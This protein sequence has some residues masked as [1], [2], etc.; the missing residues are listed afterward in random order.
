[1]FLSLPK[2]SLF[3]LFLQFQNESVIINQINMKIKELR[4]KRALR[5]VLLVLL[6]NAAGMAKGQYQDCFFAEDGLFYGIL[7]DNPSCVAVISPGYCGGNEYD[8]VNLTLTNTVVLEHDDG[9]GM[10]HDVY[11][12]VSIG[13][14][15]FGYCTSLTSIVIPNSVTTIG[16]GAFYECT[17]LASIEI[18]NL[19][20]SI[21]D[22]TFY[23][24]SSLTGNIT[25][26]NSVTKIGESAFYGC[27][28]LTGS[29]IIPNSV[30]TIGDHAF[31]GCSGFTGDLT[32]GNSVTTIGVEAF[33]R[34]TGFRGSLTIGNS[35]TTIGERAFS[36]YEGTNDEGEYVVGYMRFTGELVIP[37]S[38]TWIGNEA[39]KMCNGFTGGLTISNSVTTI[40]Y[41]T[42]S[43]CSGFT[44]N[45]TIPNSVTTIE[46]GAFSLCYGFS[47]TLRISHSVRSIGSAFYGC[48]SFKAIIVESGNIVYDSRDSCNAIIKSSTNE[49]IIGCKNTTIP[50]S[51]TAIGYDAF[52][53]CSGFTGSLTIPNSVITIGDYAFGYCSGLTGLTIPNSVTTI[54]RAAFIGC[55]HLTSITLGN[56]VTSIGNSAFNHCSILD[57]ITMLGTTPPSL[58]TNVFSISNPDFTIYVPYNSLNAYK[59][60]DN[61]SDYEPYIKPMHSPSIVGYVSST[62][63]DKW[64]LISLPLAD[65]TDPAVVINL[66]SE[67]HDYDLYQYDQSIEGEEWRN[68]KIDSFILVN[69]RG[70]LYA[71]AVD[72]NLIIRGEFNEDET[73]EVSLD[74]DAGKANAGWNLVG[75]PFPCNAYINRDYYVMNE[76]GTGINP[77]AVSASTPIPPC[78]GVFVKAEGEGETVVFT[79]AEP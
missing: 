10:Q 24:C 35:V 45:L 9:Y 72:L 16:R 62:S 20:T 8:F 77:V 19:L 46:A 21:E 7:M 23:G 71:T 79:R 70:Y 48:R 76:D 29:L 49:L 75:N 1:M 28:G 25:I 17:S 51:V 11:T 2:Q 31:E 33:Y 26:P 39:F 68:N 22:E 34:C 65:N 12:L 13:D 6:L 4:L 36:G 38:V 67:D 52:N 15:A 60:A 30:T 18:P 5:S 47:D 40:S 42:F 63:N 37:N 59:T 55:T 64:K 53:D 44:G 54:G 32:I 66:L 56:S 74:Y 27:N 41:G 50:N 57:T 78:T 58:G 43:M 3:L 73:K 61:W 14:F 69:G